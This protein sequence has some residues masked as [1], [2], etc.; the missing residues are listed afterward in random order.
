MSCIHK[1]KYIAKIYNLGFRYIP[2]PLTI[3][4][5]PEPTFLNPDLSPSCQ[6]SF[7]SKIE[8]PSAISRNAAQRLEQQ[9]DQGV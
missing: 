5:E 6:T 8:L 7:S 4:P 3:N 9:S 2:K 1:K